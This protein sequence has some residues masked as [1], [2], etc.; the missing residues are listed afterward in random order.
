MRFDFLKVTRGLLLGVATTLA[1]PAA[2]EPFSAEHLVRIP[3]VGAPVAAPDGDTVAFTVRETDMEAGRGRTDLWTVAVDGDEAARRLT[4]HEANDSDP[5][6]GP[7]SSQLYFLSARSGSSQ[8]WRIAIDGGEAQQVTDLPLDVTTFALAPDGRR[9]ALTLSV[10]PDCDDL[11]CTVQR[12]AAQASADGAVHDRLFMRHWDH[13]LDGTLSRLFTLEI[14]DGRATGEPVLVSGPVYG[15]VPSSPFGG[16][17]E[18]TFGADG[19]ALYFTARIHDADEP[20]STNF[21]W[22]CPAP[23]SRPTACASWFATW[24]AARRA[25]WR[26]AGIG[27]PRRSPWPATV[28]RSSPMPRTWATRP[29]GPSIWRAATRAA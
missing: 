28:K 8:V 25:S 1:L 15:N 2:A 18:Y 12:K 11:A 20:W 10:F 27:R 26:R 5:L 6:W 9:L 14:T 22:P 29:Y 24:P 4:S 23:A 7:D 13:W 19:S 16:G 3:R 17:E 21:G